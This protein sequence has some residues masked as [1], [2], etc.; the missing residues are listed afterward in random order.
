MIQPDNNIIQLSEYIKK[1]IKVGKRDIERAI[2]A[3]T[4]RG[5]GRYPI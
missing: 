2:S 1:A 3:W 5:R 4:Y